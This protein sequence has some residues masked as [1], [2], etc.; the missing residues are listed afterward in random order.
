MK[1]K[2]EGGYMGGNAMRSFGVT[3][4]NK[5]QYNELTQ[6][7]KSSFKNLIENNSNH[8]NLAVVPSYRNKESFGDC[9]LLSDMPSEVFEKELTNNKDFTILGKKPN[10]SVVSYAVKFRDFEPFQVD[11]IRTNAYNFDFNL[12]YLSYNDLGNLIGRI[13]AALGFKFAH[14]GLYLQAWFSHNGTSKNVERIK[15]EG[16]TNEHAEYKKE[17]LFLSDFQKAIEFLGF[18]YERFCK[19]FDELEDILKYVT[20]SKYFCKDYFDLENRNH[21]QRMRD[22]KRATYHAALEYFEN[23]KDRKRSDVKAEFKKVVNSQ[24]PKVATIKHKMKKEC[25]REYIISRRLKAAR[26]QR[27]AKKHFG[28]SLEGAALGNIMKLIKSS[29]DR[30]AAAN[31]ALKSVWNSHLTELIGKALK[32]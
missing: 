31:G 27:L 32:Q 13:A 30:S 6:A 7:I 3:R 16:K 24:F 17:C 4:L 29:C 8:Y 11:L 25:R 10:G 22:R 2:N 28:V 14:D 12:N 26:I 1:I 19:G 23:L 20:D 15:E 18:D 5:T 21:A 9:D